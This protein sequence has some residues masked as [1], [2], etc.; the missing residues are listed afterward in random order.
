MSQLDWYEGTQVRT[1]LGLFFERMLEPNF[2][3]AL[4][5]RHHRKTRHRDTSWPSSYRG[6]SLEILFE[7]SRAFLIESSPGSFPGQSNYE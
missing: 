2:T 1:R 7:P 3:W 6:T 4:Q 5:S